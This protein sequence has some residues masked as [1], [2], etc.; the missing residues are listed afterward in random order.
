MCKDSLF[1]EGLQK[2]CSILIS[3]RR[4]HTLSGTDEEEFHVLFVLKNREGVHIKNCYHSKMRSNRAER[5]IIVPP[6]LRQI[7]TTRE[8][9]SWL[10]ELTCS[11]ACVF[12]KYTSHWGR[13]CQK[14]EVSTYK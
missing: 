12:S 1:H 13:N 4:R 11:F 5:P 6:T 10:N 7:P 9:R 8:M 3:S 2:S 14:N